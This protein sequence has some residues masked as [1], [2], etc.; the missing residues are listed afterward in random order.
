MQFNKSVFTNI[1]VIFILFV[2]YFFDFKYNQDIFYIAIFAFSG[3]ITNT[4]AIHML[5]EKV[6]FIYGS[7]VVEDRF[8]FFKIGIN[9]IIMN[10]FF[11]SDKTSNLFNRVDIDF[12]KIIKDENLDFIFNDFKTIIKQSSLGGTLSMFGGDKLLDGFKEPF[13]EKLQNSLINIVSSLEFKNK[14]SIILKE[15]TQNGDFNNRVEEIIKSR[16][17]EFTPKMVKELVESFIK[18]HLQWLVIWGAVFGAI[19][20][21]FGVLL[22]NITNI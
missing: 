5:F 14:I 21:V 6:P 11:T 22:G 2:S 3:S 7:G 18:Q 8:E 15:Q 9:N 17:D 4:I 16:L 10:N 20:G 12:G 13:V 19:I 1:S